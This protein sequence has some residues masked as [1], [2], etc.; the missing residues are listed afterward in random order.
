V[1][2]AALT[3]CGE[4]DDTAGRAGGT[5]R[6]PTI[7]GAPLTSVLTAN[8]Y[9]FDPA[10][11][12][13]DGDVLTFRIMGRPSWATFAT[14]TGRLTGTPTAADLGTYSNIVISVTDGAAD[15]TLAPFSVTVVATATGSA[16]LS[17][18]PPT[19]N[20][21]GSLLANLGGYRIYWGTAQGNFANSVTVNNPG[22]T[23]YVVD[24]LTPATWYF[25]TTAVNSAGLE[26]GRSNIVSKTVL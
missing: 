13:E 26:S 21:D 11:S 2:G 16:T 25:A 9:E 3:G 24:Q 10:A 12:D 1:L 18:T 23:S 19:Q 4:E 8:A 6:A 17:W 20:A 22:L 15:A 14:A 7:S 5:N